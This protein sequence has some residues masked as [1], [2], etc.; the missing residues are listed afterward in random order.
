MTQQ[1]IPRGA[2]AAIGPYHQ[3][4]RSGDLLFCS[5]QL[6]LDPATGELVAG[7]TAAQAERA[8]RPGRRARCRRLH[9]RRCGQGHDLHGGHGRLRRGQCGLHAI[10]RPAGTCRS[11][12]AV[13]TLPKDALIELE[14]IAV[15][16]LVRRPR[17]IAR[18]PSSL[19][20]PTGAPTMPPPS[21]LS[22]STGPNLRR[23]CPARQR[24]QP[25]GAHPAS[26]RRPGGH[27]RR[28]RDAHALR[29]S[30]GAPPAVRPAHARLR[31]GCCPG[32]QR[33]AF[34]VVTSPQTAGVRDAFGEEVDCGDPGGA[35][36]TGDALR[37]RSRSS[38]DVGELLVLSGDVPRLRADLLVELLDQRRLDQ[39][40]FALTAVASY[41]PTRPGP[42]DPQRGR[43][44]GAHRGGEGPSDD[45]R[46]VAEIN[47]GLYAFEVRLAARADR[48]PD[49][50]AGHAELYL[51]ELVGI[52]RADGRLVA[53]LDVDDDGRLVGI[54]DHA[55]LAQAEWDLR[56][57]LDGTWMRRGVTMRDPSTGST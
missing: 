1:A 33:K 48:D 34:L 56:T 44:G 38:P 43:R 39:A 26:T 24:V 27:G 32:G 49:P 17:R 46:E 7:G 54:N 35:A 19:T 3:A 21:N 18:R 30:Q 6:G 50:F 22:S 36:G 12:V 11:T 40:A 20:L 25:A 9:L 29:A 13:K 53:S 14:A 45:E 55:Q 5:G 51:T 23:A 4:I 8:L 15:R 2:P 52:A 10:L 41:D 37:P 31:A 47:A 16:S 42:R 28:P 57:G